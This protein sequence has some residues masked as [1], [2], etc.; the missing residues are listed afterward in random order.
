[1][2]NHFRVSGVVEEEWVSSIIANMDAIHFSDCHNIHSYPYPFFRAKVISMFQQPDMSQVLM[3]EWA[4][5][6]QKVD[7]DIT[8][9]MV[10]IQDLVEKAFVG[11]AD[12][13][14]QQLA[15]QAFCRGMRDQNIAQLVTLT[16]KD[17]V[18]SALSAVSRLMSVPGPTRDPADPPTS[19]V[20]SYRANASKYQSYAAVDDTQSQ[21][22]ESQ[23]EDE[24][25]G[26][27]QYYDATD[28]GE[29]EYEVEE[30]DYDDH[31][32]GLAEVATTSRP[33]RGYGR[34]RGFRGRPFRSRGNFR[35]R[36]APGVCHQC[37]R[38]GHYMRDCKFADRGAPRGRTQL[39]LRVARETCRYCGKPGHWQDQCPEWQK[40]QQ[41]PNTASARPSAPSSQS[42]TSTQNPSV[43]AHSTTTTHMMSAA[44][45]VDST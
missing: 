36:G 1:M 40:T 32:Y 45:D 39:I 21:Q 8:T 20:R 26:E 3:A 28:Y 42:A 5:M 25:G 22:Y 27:E 11:Y 37:G 19:G 2:E 38:P 13:Q 24:Y 30:G 4:E 9:F 31:E 17:N 6:R 33:Y 43:S 44:S 16:A 10:R 14:K 7:E 12:A 23:Q 29:Q 35:G 34:P 18:N 15:V 41:Q